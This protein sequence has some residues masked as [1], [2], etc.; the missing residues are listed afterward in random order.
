MV[1]PADDGDC[2]H[3]RTFLVLVRRAQGYASLHREARDGLLTEQRE[4]Y[5]ALCRELEASA[6]RSELTGE[7]KVRQ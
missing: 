7:V 2:L 1:L 3:K 4:E 5:T 6:A